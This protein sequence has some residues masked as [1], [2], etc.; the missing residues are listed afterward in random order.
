MALAPILRVL[1]VL[2][3]KTL[4]LEVQV[5]GGLQAHPGRVAGDG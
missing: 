2:P 1:P 4:H 5:V 3:P